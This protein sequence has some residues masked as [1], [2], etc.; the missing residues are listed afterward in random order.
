MERVVII[1]T[2]VEE[3]FKLSVI[4]SVVVISQVVRQAAGQLL[5]HTIR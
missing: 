5:R 3:T 4:M 1:D 2:L